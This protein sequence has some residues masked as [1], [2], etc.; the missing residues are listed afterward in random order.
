MPTMP[1]IAS[2]LVSAADLDEDA[3]GADGQ[4]QDTRGCAAGGGALDRPAEGVGQD[5]VLEAHPRPEAQSA[6]AEPADRAGRHLDHKGSAVPHAEL[7]VDR[8]L[9]EPETLSWPP[10]W[11]P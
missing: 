6:R 10:A 1:G 8:T 4:H 5:E 2:S 7:G 9:R 11:P 3:P